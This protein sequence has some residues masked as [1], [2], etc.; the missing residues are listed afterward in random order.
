MQ[1]LRSIL[2]AKKKRDLVGRP[3]RTTRKDDP[4]GRP[5]M[6]TQK[7]LLSK[8]TWFRVF[9]N[10]TSLFFILNIDE[11]RTQKTHTHTH[12]HTR[13]SCFVLQHPP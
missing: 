4:E 5:G 13:N 1:I 9:D 2:M 11:I 3:G 12:K 7:H 8:D 6:T 10:P